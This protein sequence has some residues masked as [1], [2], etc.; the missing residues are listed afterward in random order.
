MEKT[1]SRND[2]AKILLN[3]CIRRVLIF[4][5]NIGSASTKLPGPRAFWPAVMMAVAVVIAL[6][7]NRL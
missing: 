5:H 4:S 7:E 6:L 2:E 3:A 1:T